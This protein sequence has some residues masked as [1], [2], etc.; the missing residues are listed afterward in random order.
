[1]KAL[2]LALLAATTLQAQP[3]SHTFTLPNGLRVVH[4]EDRERPLV[5]V[6]LLLRVLPS[7][8]P[9]GRPGLALLAGRMLT[10][11]GGPR[12]EAMDRELEAAGIRLDTT[13]APEGLTWKLAARNR[14]QDRAMG[15]L[16]EL[17]LRP[18]L[19]PQHLAACRADC[20]RD[21]FKPGA[22]PADRLRE[23]LAWDP[24]DRPT[25][26]SLLAIGP[27]DLGTF[28]QRV[29]RPERATLI[30]HGDL[31]PEQAKRLVILNFG[32]WPAGA[33]AVVP[34]AADTPKAL[35][36]QPVL[37][38][39]S[40][41]ALRIQALAPI[42]GDL[43]PESLALLSLLV[44]GDPALAPLRATWEGTGLALT[45]DTPAAGGR[46]AWALFFGRLATLAQRGFT[47]MDLDR[48]RRSWSA[49]RSLEALD[50]EA[51]LAQALATLAGQT[52]TRE[53]LGALTLKDLNADLRLWL[54]PS[55]LRVGAVGP[56]GTLETL[57]IP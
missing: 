3:R 33:S 22:N 40:G 12:T 51:Q 56:A 4:L 55:R 49:A 16:A 47:P 31:G 19:N 50:P 7:D 9:P 11:P 43:R 38:P 48:A 28:Q 36:A 21:L 10:G 1:M 6:S 17:V 35:P 53:A 26:A 25:E 2:L 41:P 5:R 14:E 27:E 37:L 30:L 29:F 52:P 23:T 57:A 15:L 44:P 24:A 42:V 54:D 45:L 13:S 8:T 18:I 46:E 20:L 32:S 34:A 39:R